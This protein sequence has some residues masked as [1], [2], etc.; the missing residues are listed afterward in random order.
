MYIF[1]SYTIPFYLSNEWQIIFRLN[2]YF[3]IFFYVIQRGGINFQDLSESCYQPI[4]FIAFWMFIGLLVKT[5][6]NKIKK[7]T[8]GN[9]LQ[10]KALSD[11]ETK[12]K[13]LD[14]INKYLSIS[15]LRERKIFSMK[16]L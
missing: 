1:H 16:I 9:G 10:E 5:D 12:I 4:A 15:Y 14:A 8:E 11:K 3:Y 6:K 13:K 7:L 2:L